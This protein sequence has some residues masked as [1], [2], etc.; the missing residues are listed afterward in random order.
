MPKRPSLVEFWSFLVGEQ[1]LSSPVLKKIGD[2]L[3]ASSFRIERL[4]IDGSDRLEL[5]LSSD[6][7]VD[8]SLV[9]ELQNALKVVLRIQDVQIYL[10]FSE[11]ALA[12]DQ[13]ACMLLPWLADEFRRSRNGLTAA[14]LS[15]LACESQGE[16]LTIHCPAGVRPQFSDEFVEET[17][18][19]YRERAGIRAG[20][21]RT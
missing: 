3:E 16:E 2:K 8:G 7:Q 20:A 10:R 14:M 4:K 21:E 19:F 12:E 11:A 17:A 15:S 9:S 6:E 18:S 13:T 5:T 1:A